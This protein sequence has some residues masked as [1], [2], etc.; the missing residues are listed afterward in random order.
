MDG[1]FPPSLESI[2]LPAVP[3]TSSTQRP[4]VAITRTAWVEIPRLV[5]MGKP[6]GPSEPESGETWWSSSQ[7]KVQNV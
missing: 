1:Y 2:E 7:N 3:A 4:T 5:V 6:Q